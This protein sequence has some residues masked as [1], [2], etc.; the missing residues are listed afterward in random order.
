MAIESFAHNGLEVLYN[1]GRS[2]DIQPASA[3]RK[4]LRL[5]DL[6]ENAA[7]LVDFHGVSHF[8]R[9][10]GNR[11]RTYPFNVTANWRLTFKFKNGDAFD[12]NY[13]DYH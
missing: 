13:E 11:R 8:H 4:L 6:I 9:M 5:M 1:T 10:T 2:P 7:D 3:R 12:L